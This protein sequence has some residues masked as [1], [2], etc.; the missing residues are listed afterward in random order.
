MD[1][2]QSQLRPFL[3]Q[4]GFRLRARTLNRTM[5]DGLV[6]VINFQMGQR[7]LQGKF[8]VNVGVYVP[9]VAR[10]QYGPKESSFVQ[11]PE[12]CVRHRLGS[13]GPEHRDV[14]W[15]LPLE[16]ASALDLHLRLERGCARLLGA[17]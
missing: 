13:L 16:G 8:T 1:E 4:R 3:E 5:S 9:Q 17:I 2:V 6:H 11:E 7:W 10:V 12:C 15:D 14:W